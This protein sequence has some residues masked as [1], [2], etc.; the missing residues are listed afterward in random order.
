MMC[1]RALALLA[2]AAIVGY[3]ARSPNRNIQML[4]DSGSRIE[5]YWVHPDSG[6]RRLMSTNPVLFGATFPLQTFV[7][8][9]FELR[10]LPSEKTG[11]CKSADQTCRQAGFVI[12]ENDDQGAFRCLMDCVIVSL[13]VTLTYAVFL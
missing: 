13:F 11:E 10:E 3:A 12:S 2:T 9:E 1:W 7:G 4:N 6:E 8:H 5:V